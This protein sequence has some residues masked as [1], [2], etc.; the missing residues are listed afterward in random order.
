M[1]VRGTGS[2]AVFS[3]ALFVF[4]FADLFAESAS[5]TLSAAASSPAMALVDAVA[6]ISWLTLILPACLA[7]IYWRL[8]AESNDLLAVVWHG[9]IAVGAWVGL[10]ASVVVST[11]FIH[12]DGSREIT[13]AR[14]A[15][16]VAL[17]VMVA[18]GL[19]AAFRGR[20]E[21]TVF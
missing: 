17:C 1:I 14:V 12:L 15:G 18:G 16:N 7:I 11:V 19:Y 8:R 10:A 2:F 20:R 5:D 13:G 21:G 9:L 6:P 4:V 3:L